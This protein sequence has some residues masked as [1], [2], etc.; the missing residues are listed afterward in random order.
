[1][2]ISEKKMLETIWRVWLDGR[3]ENSWRT[4]R[5]TSGL[6]TVELAGR[7]QVGSVVDYRTRDVVVQPQEL[8]DGM[9]YVFIDGESHILRPGQIHDL[10]M[11]YVTTGPDGKAELDATWH[12]RLVSA[13][14]IKV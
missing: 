13:E 7:A 4:H 9:L 2:K 5:I 10:H 6:L 14:K 1:M 8:I 3:D 12:L 11:Q